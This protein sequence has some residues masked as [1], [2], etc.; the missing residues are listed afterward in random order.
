MTD[1]VDA[2]YMA[3]LR[4][5]LGDCD[6]AFQELER[7]FEE[8]SAALPILNIDPKMDWLRRD[9]RFGHLRDRLF[10]DANTLRNIN[11]SVQIAAAC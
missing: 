11:Q 10:G 8:S 9:P 4:D 7:A 6:G 5:A 3:L 1:Y 2:Y